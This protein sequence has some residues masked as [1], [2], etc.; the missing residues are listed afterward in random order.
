MSGINWRKAGAYVL[1]ALPVLGLAGIAVLAHQQQQDS[2][3]Q[4]AGDPLADA[5]RKAREQKKESP[6]PKKV[7][8]NDD[9]GSAPAAAP[10]AT[11]EKGE[12]KQNP[13]ALE[14]QLSEP[15]TGTAPAEKS[16]APAKNTEEE[17]RKRFKEARQNL[18]DAQKELDILQRE[19]QKAQVQYYSDP[20]KALAEQYTRQDVNDLDAKIDAKK[21]EVEK[22]KQHLS[23]MEDE[24]RRSGGEIGWSRE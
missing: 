20:Q 21:Q 22:I 14:K 6:K 16:A 2:A 18:A 8:T 13:E 23:D 19:S 12:A 3:Q 17:W 4:P 9:V 1:V 11:E 5:A 10:A 24:L 15:T 7:Y